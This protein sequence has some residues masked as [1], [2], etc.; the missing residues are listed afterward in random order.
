V[1]WVAWRR[2]R[3]ETLIAA[4]I[5]AVLVLA[6]VPTGVEMASAYHHD[7]LSGC[8]GVNT[9]LSCST[10]LQSFTSRFDH[11]NSFVSWLTLIPGLFGVLLAAPFVL[12]LENGTHRLAWT[13]SITRG[14]W[15]AHKLA[16]AVGA[17]IV[18]SLVLTLLVTWWRTPYVHLQGRMTT[19]TYDSEGIVVFGYTLFALGLVAA[20]GAVWRRAVP[21]LV[22]G[23]VGYFAARI[24]VDTWLR[25]RLLTPLRIS[26]PFGSGEP[27]VLQH[28]W[29]ISQQLVDASGKPAPP[30]ILTCGGHVIAGSGKQALGKCLTAHGVRLQAIYEPASRFWPLQ[31]IETGLFAGTALV[32]L[33]FAAWWTHE[34]AA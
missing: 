16:V 15:I 12:E 32:L 4:G 5:V 11:L 29:G 27:A 8:L 24:F 3:T 1:T 34:R 13:Q 20:V 22:T 23:F 18:A 14:R 7:G 30:P 9:S 10:E 28:A 19:S 33:L 26:W 2:Q 31:G 17:A 21:A 25:Q 6:L